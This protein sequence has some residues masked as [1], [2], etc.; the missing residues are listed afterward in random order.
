M[1]GGAD[2]EVSA[3]RALLDALEAL[4]SH[5]EA[6]VLIG[7]QAVYLHTGDAPVALAPFTK[8]VDLAL[9]TRALGGAPLIEDA[10]AAADF[11]LDPAARQPGAW[12]SPTGFPVDLLV[13]EALSGP[14]GRRGARIPP[15]GS[16]NARRAAGLEAAVVDRQPVEISSLDPSDPRVFVV[17]VAGPA[18]LLV[19]KLHKVGERQAD[20]DRLLD[21][22]AHDIYR[23][24]TGPTA[25]LAERLDSLR[26]DDLAGDS[27]AEALQFLAALFSVPD[28]LGAVMA[29]RAEI[30]VGSPEVVSASTAALAADLLDALP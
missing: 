27:T 5:A 10:M 3:R 19:S 6:V 30:A 25:Q 26:R 1:P 23:L 16:T 21:K 13:P 4:G 20:P 29:G 14:Q 11:V 22:D 7:A 18:A 24:L 8:D 28:A 2:F 12:L 9:D 17:R 15:H